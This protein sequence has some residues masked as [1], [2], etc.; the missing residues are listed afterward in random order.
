MDVD[1]GWKAPEE[2]TTTKRKRRKSKSV[3][4]D[5]GD[6]DGMDASFETVEDAKASVEDLH[7]Y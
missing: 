1:L 2:A 3:G 7:N 6:G 5:E 4:D